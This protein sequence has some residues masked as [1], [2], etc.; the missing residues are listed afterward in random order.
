MPNVPKGVR[1]A[2]C[3]FILLTGAAALAQGTAGDVVLDGSEPSM[4]TYGVFLRPKTTHPNIGARIG[5]NTQSQSFVVFDSANTSL[6]AVRGNGN[7]VIGP[8]RSGVHARL[9]VVATDATTNTNAATTSYGGILLTNNVDSSM[10]LRTLGGGVAQ[11]AT[12]GS[13]RA[14]SL[15]SGPFREA[16]RI[17]PNQNVGIGTN[18]PS[19][20]LHVA[21]SLQVG[22]HL[23]LPTWTNVA[24]VHTDGYLKLVTPI[25]HTESNMFRVHI[26]GYHYW[27]PNSD[28]IDV[29][30]T[31]YAYT[32]HTLTKQTCTT[33]GTALPVAIGLETRTGYTEP[34]VVIRI[35]TPT[36][37]WYYPHFTAEY[38][39]W[40]TKNAADFLWVVASSDPGT[41]YSSNTNNV[42]IDDA[43]GTLTLG[44]AG[45]GPNRLTVNGSATVT[46][47]I[48]ATGTITGVINATYQDIAEWVPTTVHVAPGTVVVL[49]TD[50][51][52]EVMPSH[53][54]YDTGVAGVVSAQPGVIL[55]Q[56]GD[57]KAK[58]ATYGRVKVRVDANRAPIRIGDLLVTSEKPGTAMKSVAV[59]MNGIPMH[60][61]GTVLGKA[62]EPLASGEGEIL[63]LLSLQ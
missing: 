46:G 40:K 35:G 12:D 15:A 43:N 41:G 20:K 16:V 1:A 10:V 4:T 54:A 63:V 37:T 55:G 52:N 53:R 51:V 39:G 19:A 48:T 28:P 23:T 56:A 13:V 32:G 33:G 17:D 50:K 21:G 34:V 29:V 6:L 27:G 49:N 9:E 3:L 44:A 36:T 61:P 58:I 2:V 26:K 8:G 25:V 24:N 11:I 42:M 62:L 38:T 7:V 18:A 31:G 30:C 5:G 22:N 45:T 14:L 47:N 60:R 57:A 59:E